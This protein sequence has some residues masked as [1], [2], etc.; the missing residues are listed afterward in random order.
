MDAGPTTPHVDHPRDAEGLRG[1]L[2]RAGYEAEAILARFGGRKVSYL[3]E[4][5][6][7]YLLCCTRGG[8][9]LDTLIRLF[10]IGAP[11]EAGDVR[12]CITPMSM[13]DWVRMGLIEVRGDQVLA[14]IHWVPHEGLFIAS[15]RYDA[16]RSGR[17]DV[18]MG[19]G[20]TTM[21]L[22][23]VR[24]PHHLGASLDLG[25]GCGTVAMLAA[26]QSDRVVATDTN[27]RAV[28]AAKFNA[29]VNGLDH[30]ECREGSFFEPV[31]GEQFDLIQSNPP[32]VISP[33]DRYAYRDSGLGLEG[34]TRAIV[35]G[36]AD[37]LADGGYCQIVTNWAQV[38]GEDW[39]DRLTAWADGTGCDMWV[40]PHNTLD[41]GAYAVKW[42]RHTEQDDAES[43]ARRYDAWVA[44]YERE[45][46]ETVFG[47][48][49]VLRRRSGD[50]WFHVA[51]DLADIVAPAGEGIVRAF[52]AQDFLHERG[53]GGGLLDQC[54]RVAPEARLEQTARCEGQ[55]WNVEE[56]RL[57]IDT[58]L[59]ATGRTDPFMA[60]LVGGCDGTRP[61]RELVGDMAESLQRDMSDVAP[62]VLEL[63]RGMVTSG[64]LLPPERA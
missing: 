53:A 51:D 64:F 25:T 18:L 62:S 8:A 26:A 39:R 11:V 27:P 9:P 12:R 16:F 41:P 42:I 15:D 47:G 21:F 56:V 6:R 33:E 32:F 43:F 3:A 58:G 44:Y 23:A 60:R 37:V 48:L 52:A 38:T 61:L 5:E 2:E 36:A 54:L 45:H 20:S 22:A 30:I 14:T 46:V 24:V 34:V 28:A 50:N 59:C 57:V 55:D 49:I 40:A 10:L 63:V 13:D 35:Q 29:R 4:Q 31:R 19:I 7:P 1:V 17:A